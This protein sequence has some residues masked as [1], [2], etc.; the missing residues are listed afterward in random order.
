[1]AYA[2]DLPTGGN[3]V[4]GSA[5]IGQTGNTMTIDQST[6]R[7]AINWQTFNIGSGYTVQFNQPGSTSIT[8]NRVVGGVP[9][10]IQ[11]SLLA[12]GQVWIQNANGVLFGSG[13]TINVNSLLVTTKNIDVNQFMSGS[14]TFDLTSTG[15]NAGI[16][17][18]GS[19]T[20]HGYV[21][22]VGD[23]VR[24]T[25]D[26]NA[27]KVILAAGDSATVSLNNGQGISVELTKGS[28]NALIENTGNINAGANG[29][30][31]ITAQGAN[32]VLNTI[33]NLEGVIQAGSVNADAKNGNMVVSGIID[34]SDDVVGAGFK[35]ALADDETTWAGLKPAPTQDGGTIILKAM[36]GTLDASKATLN[37]SGENN[38]G[39]IETSGNTVNFNGI[40]INALGKNGKAGTWLIDPADFIVDSSNVVSIQNALGLVNVVISTGA[41]ATTP[42][43]LASSGVGD[44]DQG[45]ITINT[46]ISW[47]AATT[48]TLD[49]YHS[50]NIYAPITVQ[51]N[52]GGV[53]IKTND[54]T[55]GITSGVL[56]FG[57]N[58]NGVSTGFAGSISYPNGSTASGNTL[59]VNGA[60]YN[61][62]YSM[63]QLAAMAAAVGNNYALAKSLDATPGGTD[64][65]LAYTTAVVGT[66]GGTFEGLGNTISNLT[67]NVSTANVNVG[68]FGNSTGT[69]RDIGLIGGGVTVNDYSQAST[70]TSHVGALV[71]NQTGGLIT[72]A[73]ATTPVYSGGWTGGLVGF[74]TNGSILNAYATGDV[75]GHVAGGLVGEQDNNSALTVSTISN[76]YATGD[77][78]VQA[79]TAYGGGLIGW[80]KVVLA[81]LLPQII[82]TNAYATGNVNV[83]NNDSTNSNDAR[84]GGLIGY[85]SISTT[86]NSFNPIAFYDVL[87][88]SDVHATGNVSNLVNNAAVATNFPT[89]VGGLI[90]V[91]AGSLTNAYATGD[92]TSTGHNYTGGLIGKTD[93][94]YRA[95][96]SNVY[97]TGAVSNLSTG[98]G[99]VGSF[100]A[101]QNSVGGLIGY[102]QGYG[103]ADSMLS[104]AYATGP[105]SGSGNVGG[106]MGTQ[107]GS[108]SDVY[109]T[110]AVRC[111]TGSGCAIGGLVGVQE[112]GTQINFTTVT[113]TNVY[114][115]GA[116]SGTGNFVGGLIGYAG[117]I[118]TNAYFDTQTTGQTNA[119]GTFFSI[120]AI[121]NASG[122]TPGQTTSALQNAFPLATAFSGTAF[123]GGNGGLYPYLN[124]F[125]PNGVQA[126]SGFAYKDAGTTPDA[127]NVNGAVTVSLDANGNLVSQATTGK[128]GYY[129]LFVPAGT[130][131]AD[132]GLITY[133]NTTNGTA[134]SAENLA[135][136]AVA[137]TS[138]TEA[139]AAT[140]A[141]GDSVAASGLDLWGTWQREYTRLTTL[142]ALN[143]SFAQAVGTDA[144][145]PTL[146]ADLANQRIDASDATGF[147]I[148]TP[149][150]ADV[151]NDL[152]VAATVGDLTIASGATATAG[153]DVTLATLKSFINLQGSDAVTAGTG[154]WL[155]YS[156]SP[157][158]DTFGPGAPS[159]YLNSGNT[160]VWNTTWP[161]AVPLAATGNRYVF[162]DP[163]TI[164]VTTINDTKTYGQTTTTNGIANDYTITGGA[165]GV[166]GAFLGDS[167]VTVSGAPVITSAGTVVSATVADSPYAITAS[168]GTLSNSSGYTFTFVNSGLLTVTPA[169]L[170]ITGA[171][172]S[173]TYNALA[174]TNTYTVTGLQGGDTVTGVT[175]SGSG[176][177]AA[178]YNDN[179]S[180]ATISSGAGNYTITY[181]NGT[182][183]ITPALLTITIV[184]NPTKAYDGTTTATLIPSNYQIT[185]LAGSETASIS[186]TLG[187]YNSADPASA[188]TVTAGLGSGDISGANGFKASNYLLPGTASGQGTIT[189]VATPPSP[190]PAPAGG[191]NG[192]GDGDGGGG[193][194]GAG[195]AAG[196]VLVA[197]LIGWMAY[198]SGEPWM[199]AVPQPLTLDAGPYA[200]WC[201]AMLDYVE[202]NAEGTEAFVRLHTHEGLIERRLPLKDSGGGVKHFA[203]DDVTAK[204]HADL[205]FN[206]DTHEYFY[207][208]TGAGEQPYSVKAHGW[209]TNKKPDVAA[210]G[211]PSTDGQYAIEACEPQ[212]SVVEETPVPVSPPVATPAPEPEWKT[213]QSEKPVRI[214]GASFAS[215]SAKLLP[216]ANDRLFA[217]LQAAQDHPEIALEVQG[218]TDS[219]GSYAVNKNLSERRAAAVKDWL[220][221]RGIPSNRITAAGMA[222]A[223]PVASN[224]TASGRALNRRVEVK[225]VIREETRVR[226]R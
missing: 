198:D 184:G 23:Q 32:T 112:N 145:I 111:T 204:I 65:G 26:I 84:I 114:A 153:H 89:Y 188:T 35:P 210:T 208:E 123:S 49:A 57:L 20:A 46:G 83:L 119:V 146:A 42:V 168:L 223:N 82:L 10:N 193:G 4:G 143:T 54:N 175:G 187:A 142:T 40:S 139:S 7:A 134:R 149:I 19:I 159:T 190:P 156:K 144:N 80:Q 95:P 133:I 201:N 200:L 135:A 209:L 203:A 30:V 36:D 147:T 155:V 118:S 163:V 94:A 58:L 138:Y 93:A 124:A 105:V 131:T 85:Q 37:A 196:G 207:Q 107:W 61:L 121:N 17:N 167:S 192:G 1:M 3:V 174:Q 199:L 97:A 28:A 68:L 53:V 186:Q 224:E 220:I 195:I 69:I 129:Y 15:I 11:G 122:L 116:V 73:Y 45:D 225:Y 47:N 96:I 172:V 51:G 39:F 177:N 38:G 18:D 70:S 64:G 67:I 76:V 120:G 55:D 136:G 185:G 22:L 63:P 2:A 5:S 99:G 106:L 102:Y 27:S 171:T 126:I 213:I 117:N 9:S 166:A 182:L 218:F 104:N 222:D 50:V 217:V 44:T 141:S 216:G 66:F 194:D 162:N 8:L 109:A 181:T 154:R 33:V 29:E 148:D 219:T 152:I 13:A 88:V 56:D 60:N 108:M 165:S 90:G 31:L 176:T 161:T 77:V 101:S 115:T 110:G 189:T 212:K 92:V 59:N 72:N 140:A 103:K 128:N 151:S 137:A 150:G 202:I 180:G 130:L 214:D 113:T 183:T 12:N 25:G 221:E 79:I 169:T 24:N 215:G 62:I 160:A 78:T 191:G 205:S 173:K 41:L 211:R 71:G 179:L 81:N 6:N 197:G 52:G 86:V 98:I 100:P 157:S 43:T 75:F 91:Q 127:S 87:R 164:T 170:T 16:I 74:L 132:Q 206:P 48:L 178:T 226:V 34:V 158:V 21:T 125:F 14:N